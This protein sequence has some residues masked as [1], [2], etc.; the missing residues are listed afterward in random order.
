MVVLNTN[1]PEFSNDLCDEIRLFFDVRKIAYENTILAGGYT[2]WH[3]QNT[4]NPFFH[5]CRV[6][7]DGS[8]A[9][10]AAYEAEAAEPSS[11]L[12]YK[13]MRKRAAKI[14]VYRALVKAAGE[15]KPWGSLTGIRPTKLMRETWEKEGQAEAERLF[16][17][18]FDV[19][20]PKIRL[21]E[22]ICGVQ[23]PVIDSVTPTE[24]DIYIGIPFC[25]SRCAYCSFSSALTSKKGDREREYVDALLREIG[26]LREIIG[27]Y[28]VR[29][30]YIG[31]GTPTALVPEQL[32]RVVRA[33]AEFAAPEFT[34]EAGRPDTITA[35]KLDILK[36]MG[37]NRISINPQ[38]TCDATLERIGRSHSTREFFAAAELARRY[39]FQAVN[40][41][42]I[43]GLPGETPEMF[44]SSV[45]DVMTQN[46]E[47]ITV[48]TLAIKRAS[49]FGM[50]NAHRFASGAQ[51]EQMLSESMARL[52]EGGYAPY[53][54]YRQKYMTGN[55]ENIGY[56]RPGTECIYNI[57]IMEETC[58]ILA[59]GAGAISKRVFP[60]AQTRIE[61]A[62]CV[63]D[64]P[65]YI[66]RVDEMAE[67]KKKL[68]C[69]PV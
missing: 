13:K 25:T 39:D 7:R 42:L 55:L 45:K 35:Q 6:Y 44:L 12:Q 69:E 32:E 64:I 17:E 53:Y 68:F 28:H 52:A 10:E 19:S 48:H 37:V 56:A 26:L 57:D 40:M 23:R 20:Q 33:G 50:A 43:L 16:R 22:S 18:E 24:L 62:P 4:E 38:T 1:T 59:F 30:V 49:A 36:S 58:S 8:P 60:S 65:G 66:A 54:M 11:V 5:T 2:I 47:N 63:K 14:C 51:A 46:P 34:V 9:G 31:G 27:G 29:S 61:R 41:D 67:R 21:L 15:E 3:R